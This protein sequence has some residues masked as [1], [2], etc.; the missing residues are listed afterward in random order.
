MTTRP[1]R[2]LL[3]ILPEAEALRAL[4]SRMIQVSR[5]DPVRTWAASAELGTVGDRSID[6]EEL[7]NGLAMIMND[8]QA[9]VAA[10]NAHAVDALVHASE[11]RHDA[12]AHA[13]LAAAELQADTERHEEALALAEAAQKLAVRHGDPGVTAL[14]IRRQGRAL[15]GLGRVHEAVKRYASAFEMADVLRDV[16]AQAE[17]AIGAGNSLE[18]AGRWEE[19]GHWYERALKAL[20]GVPPDGGLVLP[21]HWQVATTL[22]LVH[23]TLGRIEESEPWLERAESLWSRLPDASGRYFL[24]NARGQLS[25]ARGD[26]DAARTWFER[27]AA[28][29]PAGYASVVVRLNLA[30][31]LLA[32][33]RVL[34]ATEEARSAE[35]E[36]VALGVERAFPFVYRT[37]GRCAAASGNPEAF[38]LFERALAS[39]GPASSVLERA[40]TLQAYAE[41]EASAGNPDGARDLLGKAAEMYASLDIGGLRRRWVDC[42]DSHGLEAHHLD[43]HLE[44]FRP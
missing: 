34:D 37:L 35:A 24:E 12:A 10:L 16:R 41:A 21:E 25:M 38:V 8:E 28:S 14:T 15:R 42:F 27:A 6:P 7:R 3:G 1:L 9:R 18:Q 5:P 39:D 30:E 26:P 20:G 40:I 43:T 29:V 4:R 32:R 33:Q 19:A 44:T 36:A 22:H 17:S 2:E 23:R 11:R 31:C 13:L